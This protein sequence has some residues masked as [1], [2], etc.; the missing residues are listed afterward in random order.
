MYIPGC[1]PADRQASHEWHDSSLEVGQ[2][3]Q[4]RGEVVEEQW[5]VVGVSWRPL[6]LKIFGRVDRDRLPV[7]ILKAVLCQGGVLEA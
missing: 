7:A 6:G 2:A 5:S 3:V 4:V 1:Q